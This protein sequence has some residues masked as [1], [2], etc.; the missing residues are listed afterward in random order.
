MG[1]L[2]DRAG[3]AVSVGIDKL[4]G[5]TIA[6]ACAIGFGLTRR[7]GTYS[8]DPSFAVGTN[9]TISVD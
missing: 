2:V 9:Y 5:F 7:T 8:V 1:F 6:F 4:V 3:V